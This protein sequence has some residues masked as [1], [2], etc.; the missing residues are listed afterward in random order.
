MPMIVGMS[1]CS[2]F[3]AACATAFRSASRSHYFLRS[4]A[5]K[6][7]AGVRAGGARRTAV[8]IH[9]R[10]SRARRGL[11]L[12]GALT[13][14]S[15]SMVAS[16]TIAATAIFNS[17]ERPEATSMVSIVSMMPPTQRERLPYVCGIDH[18][19]RNG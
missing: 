11:P 14:V 19:E 12:D 18:F 15:T 16:T 1:L 17:M 5:G 10:A 3:G 8:R 7:C 2:F 4:V 9:G 13:I 6:G